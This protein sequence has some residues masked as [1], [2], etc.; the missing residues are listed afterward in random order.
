MSKIHRGEI[1]ESD[2]AVRDTGTRD[3]AT[4]DIPKSDTAKRH[5]APRDCNERLGNERPCNER[6]TNEGHCTEGNG[7]ERHGNEPHSKK[8]HGDD[9]CYT[10]TSNKTQQRETA[11]T[12]LAMILFTLHGPIFPGPWD[13]SKRHA[14]PGL[15][16]LALHE[17][18]TTRT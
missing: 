9:R 5:T 10:A 12:G 15:S 14:P 8:R 18:H 4:E 7:N 6:H 16:L 11:T 1:C 2:S 17:P 13:I 3:I